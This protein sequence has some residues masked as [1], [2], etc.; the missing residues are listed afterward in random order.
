MLSAET[1]NLC[2]RIFDCRYTLGSFVCGAAMPFHRVFRRGLSMPI[3]KPVFWV[4]LPVFFLVSG[5]GTNIREVGQ[6]ATS[7]FGVVLLV[8]GA[9][10]SKLAATIVAPL[11]KQSWRESM[12]QHALLNC[13]G[14]IVLVANLEGSALELFGPNTKAAIILL[15]ALSTVMTTPLARA[16][17]ARLQAEAR[18]KQQTGSDT[19]DR[20][21]RRKQH[22][23]SLELQRPAYPGGETED[24]AEPEVV[25]PPPFII[26]KLD[27]TQS[28]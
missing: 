21:R 22:S 26:S 5:L 18:E 25:S 17:A 19:P 27:L 1:L 12:L 6:S 28:V 3:R 7:L 2:A 10:A 13:R 24:E 15:A 8:S 20:S 4:F 16:L 11:L 14:T 9:I 23:P